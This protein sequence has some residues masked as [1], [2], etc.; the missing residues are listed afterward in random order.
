MGLI[1]EVSPSEFIFVTLILGGGAAWLA[2]RGVALSWDP[3][4][5]AAAW[6]LPLGA[7]VRFI[8]YALF[9]GNL[10]TLHFFIVDLVVLIAM[11]IA[12]WRVTR[13]R[14]MTRQYDWL[15]DRAGPFNWRPKS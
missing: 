2:G 6:M 4:W 11:A 7:V 15:Y 13:A 12:G 1:W 14:Q 5:K 9:S 10:L 3:L 8:H